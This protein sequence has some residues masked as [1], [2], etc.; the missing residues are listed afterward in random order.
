MLSVPE[1]NS[2]EKASKVWLKSGPLNSFF[3]EMRKVFER[4][5]DMIVVQTDAK[6]RPLGRLR[7]RPTP[8]EAKLYTPCECRFTKTTWIE[9]WLDRKGDD[10][11]AEI[12]KVYDTIGSRDLEK[13]WYVTQ[14]AAKSWTV[15]EHCDLDKTA[16]Y[17][18]RRNFSWGLMVIL[19]KA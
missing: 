8:A 1:G 3:K 14:Q 11:K 2:I 6:Q 19:L 18:H 16:P 7:P 17:Y 9:E 10:V 13:C 15:Q 4:E 12:M 5:D